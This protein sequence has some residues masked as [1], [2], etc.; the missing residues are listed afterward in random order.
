MVSSGFYQQRVNYFQARANELEKT[1]WYYSLTRLVVAIA[2]IVFVYLGF[3]ELIY[4][5]PAVLLVFLFFNLVQRQQRKEKEK[6]IA[7][8][9][10]K[11]NA[12]EEE[13]TDYNFQNFPDGK[14]FIDPH[15]PYS[16]DLDL[17]GD[18]S[19]YQYL[20]R[21][22][23]RL[24]EKKLANDLTNLLFRKDEIQER[25][26]AIG[27]LAPLLE[28][29]QQCWAN[30]KEIQDSKFNLDSLLAWLKQPPLFYGKNSFRILQW[31]LP[32]ITC[33]ALIGMLFLPALRILFFPLTFLQIAIAARYDKPITKRQDELSRYR[34]ILENYSRLFEL[35]SK[36][37]FDS[38]LL[39]K[40]QQMAK[41]ATD[42]VRELSKLINAIESRANMI[43]RLFGNGLFLY[44][45][46]TVT[47]LEAWRSR[48][49]INLP[50]W[51]ES[52]AEWDALNSFATFHYNNPHYAFAE[53]E[54]RLL[55]EGKEVGHPLIHSK[56][57]V[58]NDFSIG[59][60]ANVM[61]VTGANMAGK[62]TFLRAIGV[63]YILGLN[64]APV[65]ASQWICSMAALRSG[66]RT[67][68]S[69][70]DH[71]SYF[72]AELNRLH[73]IIEE[74]QAGKPVLILLDE[75]LK[76]TNSNDKLA[77][78]RALIRQFI[79]KNALVLI[80]TH[81][82]LLGDMEV[83]YPTGVVNTCFEGKIENDQ[84]T[85]DYKLNRGLAQRANA[86]FLMKKM[87]IIPNE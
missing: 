28:F 66:M 23:T 54:E 15:H 10:I 59:N 5:L 2:A 79:G 32:V 43:A 14:E 77:G 65:C 7:E 67:T 9:S 22:A 29:R 80:A 84:L 16:H 6:Q 12:W 52:L 46:H 58:V 26:Q 20:N 55:I 62:S 72:Y 19:M 74:L 57:R 38:K 42:H 76:G 51:L 45:F 78:S 11:L 36:Q 60:P 41:K 85:F 70:K 17:F 87:G 83:Q 64:G 31:S 34:V 27:E 69:L 56:V 75:I 48:H 40:H 86:T 44:D 3:Q 24:G 61:L 18:G 82:I 81:D 50:H 4:F 73:S 33:S 53:I 39:L 47:N 30:G 49:A 37:K 63:N 71:Q 13:T 21:C 35:M 25:Q 68:D 8:L 1:I